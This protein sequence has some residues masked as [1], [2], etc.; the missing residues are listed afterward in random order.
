MTP[1]ICNARLPL[2]GCATELY[3]CIMIKM[4][5][6]MALSAVT[7]TL[8]CCQPRNPVHAAVY[9]AG[10][11]VLIMLNTAQLAIADMALKYRMFM[12]HR[13]TGS[14]QSSCSSS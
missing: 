10:V 1:L 2:D 5:M 7:E 13:V 9:E 12:L 3:C 8:H 14:W 6:A 4:L 11:K